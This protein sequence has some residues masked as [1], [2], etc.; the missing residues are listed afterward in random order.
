[1]DYKTIEA[2]QQQNI[3]QGQQD[4]Q[5]DV[6]NANQYQQQYNQNTA[7]A[8]QAQQKVSDYADYLK[9]AGSGANVYAQQQALANQQTGYDPAQMQQ[10]MN[11][12]A[13]L[14]GQMTAANQAF[15]QPGGVNLAGLTAPAAAAYENS[16]MSP[17][18]QGV[19]AYG[20]KINS[21]NQVYQNALTQ[22]QQGTGAQVQT[23]KLTQDQL[24]N[25]YADANTQ[26]A[27]AMQQMQFYQNLAQ[28]QQGLNASQM[29]NFYTARKA[30]QDA[31]NAVAQAGYAIAQTTG[32][33]QRNTMLGNVL[34]SSTYKDYLANPGKYN[35]TYGADG[36][37]QFSLINTNTTTGG[38][39]GG[40]TTTNK[41][42]YTGVPVP[43]TGW[44]SASAPKPSLMKQLL[45]NMY[46]G[47]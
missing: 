24:Q 32:Q 33:N 30:Y 15:S 26:A 4:Y 16:I 28:T 38:G 36:T 45:G 19:S 9:G 44:L 2:Q 7:T 12:Q 13:G 39:G 5:S 21:L 27:N 3:N 42:Q 29:Q 20:A 8:Q 47:K 34:N 35:V 11:T 31:Q 18:Q 10:A 17:L 23:Q 1:M 37:P 43:K 25:S 22:A 40:G 6:A 41:Q 14:Q 46:H